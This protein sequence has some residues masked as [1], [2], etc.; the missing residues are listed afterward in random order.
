MVL[1]S[2][3]HWLSRFAPAK[4]NHTRRRPVR[5]RPRIEQF[6]DRLVPTFIM[7]TGAV[8]NSW[9]DEHNWFPKQVPVDGDT[10]DFTGSAQS[11]TCNIDESTGIASII[12]DSSWG[13]IGGTINVEA[14]L[15]VTGDF[16]MASGRF[17]GNGAVTIDGSGSSATGADIV[18]GTGGFTNN[19]TLTTG[20]PD[21][22]FNVSGT[23]TLTNNGTINVGPNGVQ[24]FPNT[25]LNN[26]GTLDFTADAY[27]SGTTGTLT[28]TG[29]V[30]KT[31]G[32][33]TSVISCPFNSSGGTIDAE[34]GTLSVGQS[35][36][37][38]I[39]GSALEAGVGGSTTAVLDLSSSGQTPVAYTGSITGSGSGTVA[40][41]F[42]TLQIGAA[43]ATFKLPSTLFQGTG[44]T[45]DISSG[46]TLTNAGVL[47]INTSIGTTGEADLLGS[48]TAGGT[49]ANSGTI[50]EAGKSSLV[51]KNNATLSNAGT[52]DFTGDASVAP[53]LIG[54]GEGA[55]SNTGTLEKTG[56]T[57]ES[58][59]TCIF[60]NTNGAISVQTGTLVLGDLG[61]QSALSGGRFTVSRGA[62]L[63]LAGDGS[64]PVPTV[65]YTGTFT[66]TGAGTVAQQ[67]LLKVGAGGTT[68]NMAGNLFQWIA[69]SVI[70]V[71]SGNFTNIGTMNIGPEIV[72]GDLFKFQGLEGA[73]SLIN[74]KSIISRAGLSLED[75]ATLNNAKGATI[76]ILDGAID[77]TSNSTANPGGTIA[78]AGTLTFK[79]P[80]PNGGNVS[81]ANFSNTGTVQVLSG[82]MEISGSSHGNPPVVFSNTATVQVLS[83]TLT[84]GATVTQVSGSTL[85]A[86]TWIVKHGA[87]SN[88]TLSII[89]AGTSATIP[90][91]IIGSKAKVTLSGPGTAFPNLSGLSAILAGGSFTLT[92]GQSFTTSA[93]LTNSGSLTLSPGSVLT[94]GGSFTQGSSGTLT[95]QLGGTS[96]TPTLGQLFST[97]GTVALG[98]N[99]KV[100]ATVAPAVDSIF[101]VLNNEDSS[102]V[103]GSF[104][105][106]PEG[107]TFTVAGGGATMTFQITYVGGSGN[108]VVITRIS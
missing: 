34:S 104:A 97:S 41:K 103:S 29:T 37:G 85:T 86:G 53:N 36:G 80:N 52:F 40:L 66:G 100:T 99:L 87:T 3:R 108:D 7:W 89:D 28:N 94:V 10:A 77:G 54:V 107:A 105:G 9:S 70:D 33:G 73:G 82:S 59:I 48:D 22:G 23:G 72:I 27:I 46:G 5:F 62:T 39:N 83:G 90:L 8:S 50:N 20:S 106:L 47:N 55:L 74:K 93:S 24:L 57:G 61:D 30:E 44:G 58:K 4:R 26:V 76:L 71:S 31:A 102:A 78:N 68:F 49:L 13:P 25:T 88:S 1:S 67:G 32:T 101:M 95:V 92:G 43:G 11:L 17:G 35:V 2:F 98:G 16:V 51:L 42:G 60:L 6:E 38:T 96:S 69:G 75:G 79:D 12:M 21:S 19:G 18:L 45:I 65:T 15:T 56:G 14:D 63:D 64:T 91:T 84:I 81:A